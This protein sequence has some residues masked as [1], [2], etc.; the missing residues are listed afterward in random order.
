MAEMKVI[1]S[2]MKIEIA[3]SGMLQIVIFIRMGAGMLELTVAI[4]LSFDPGGGVLIGL[5]E[6][7]NF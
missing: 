5:E 4:S 1:M 2:T 6:R 7:R 3:D